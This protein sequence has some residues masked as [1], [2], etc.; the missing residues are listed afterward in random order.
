MEIELE[1]SRLFYHKAGSGNKNLLLFHGFGQDHTVFFPLIES[2]KEDFT[3][4]AFDLFHHGNSQ[5]SGL[6]VAIEKHEWK[7]FMEAFIFRENLDSFSILGF[8]IGGRLALATFEE[9]AETTNN[10]ILVAAEGLRKNFWYSWAT[11]P[12]FGQPIF[13]SL[14]NHPKVLFGPLKIAK[15]LKLLPPPLLQ[16]VLKQMD[17][18]EKR[19]R[20]YSS[21]ISLR[22]LKLSIKQ[23]VDLSAGHSVRIIFVFGIDDD[24][25]R[26][27]DAEHL[28][29]QISNAEFKFLQARHHQLLRRMPEHLTAWLKT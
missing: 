10:L 1:G 6:D 12:Q 19:Q 14:I 28:Q 4:F 22:K 29:K 23:L 16:F 18:A 11:H 8:S 24:I 17:S 3:C 2:L 13:H 20:V 26:K 27:A 7:K 5:R 21:W 25:M 9:F 15:A